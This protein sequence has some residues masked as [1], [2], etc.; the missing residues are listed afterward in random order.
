MR[1]GED[2]W[3]C[4]RVREYVRDPLGITTAPPGPGRGDTSG[5]HHHA[6]Q[7]GAHDL[8]IHSDSHTGTPG[9]RTG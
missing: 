8:R 2:N 7:R 6:S 9:K 1:P 4:L 3:W 5:R